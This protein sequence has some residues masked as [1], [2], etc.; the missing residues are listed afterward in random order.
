MGITQ[1]TDGWKNFSS[2]I[3]DALENGTDFSDDDLL[4]IDSAAPTIFSETNFDLI[5]AKVKKILTLNIL[6]SHFEIFEK[7]PK[8]WKFIYGNSMNMVASE[9]GVATKY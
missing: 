2:F 6:E 9:Y 5:A 1:I 4:K 3:M 8:T 7:L